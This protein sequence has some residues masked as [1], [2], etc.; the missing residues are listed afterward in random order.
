MSAPI[1]QDGIASY[2]CDCLTGFEG[3]H[4]SEDIDECATGLDKCTNGATC[5]VSIWNVIII[6]LNDI[7]SHMWQNT[8]GSYRCM[9][10]EGFTGQFCEIDVDECDLGY[11]KNGATCE[12][13][14]FSDMMIPSC[15]M[16]GLHMYWIRA[17]CRTLLVAT[18][19]HALNITLV[20]IVTLTSMSAWWM[21]GAMKAHVK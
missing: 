16:H 7:F 6:I 4:C 3:D 20:E 14:L 5:S 17:F 15:T 19:A 9:C 8:M 11:C 1:T 13:I 10:S 2:T 12:V 21:T 18:A